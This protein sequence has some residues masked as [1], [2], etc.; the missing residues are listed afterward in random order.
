MGKHRETET[1]KEKDRQTDRQMDRQTDRPATTPTPTLLRLV[2]I[3]V[4]YL[5]SLIRGS[6]ISALFSPV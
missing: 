5:H 1:D 3:D 4:T 6:Y 2:L